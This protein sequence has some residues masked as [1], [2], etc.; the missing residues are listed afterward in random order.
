[1][2]KKQIMNVQQFKIKDTQ[3]LMVTWVPYP[4]FWCLKLLVNKWEIEPNNAVWFN[5]QGDFVIVPSN[6]PQLKN[7]CIVKAFEYNV[8]LVV[9]VMTPVI[10]KID[11]FPEVKEWNHGLFFLNWIS[12]FKNVAI[13]T[14]SMD[15][16]P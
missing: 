8:N 12:Q 7:T 6:H 15:L 10:Y 3:A 2:K 14:I 1:M 13:L 5:S 9:F 16:N 11:V 4:P